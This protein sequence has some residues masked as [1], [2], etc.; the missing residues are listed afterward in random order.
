MSVDKMTI[1]AQIL[2]IGKHLFFPNG[3][4]TKGQA[5]DFTFD[6]CDFKRNKIPPDD[7]VARLYEQTRLKLLRF[8]ICTKEG[9]STDEDSLSK[10][11]I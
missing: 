2:N 6:V 1:V 4:S 8:Y 5:A 11:F 10:G 3:R 9:P 7:T